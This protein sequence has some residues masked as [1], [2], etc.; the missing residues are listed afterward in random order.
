VL[1][2]LYGDTNKA[3][4][5]PIYFTVMGDDDKLYRFTLKMK[6]VPNAEFSANIRASDAIVF[7]PPDSYSIV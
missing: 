4:S 2:F 1:A 7:L 6:G 3:L 5:L